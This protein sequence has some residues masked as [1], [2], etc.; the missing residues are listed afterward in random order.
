[1]MPNPTI[2]D[3]YDL[4]I[5]VREACDYQSNRV[6]NLE[7]RT[8]AVEGRLGVVEHRLEALEGRVTHG[9]DRV[10][11]RFDRMDARFDVLTNEMRRGFEEIA[12]ALRRRGPS[13][14]D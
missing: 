13:R 6:D 14:E 8:S 2:A 10:D 4:V 11:E 7:S 12:R 1:M 9:F 3:V 5:T